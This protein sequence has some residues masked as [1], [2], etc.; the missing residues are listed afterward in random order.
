M[1]RLQQSRTK[2]FIAPLIAIIILVAL[3]IGGY[4]FLQYQRAKNEKGVGV[5][6]PIIPEAPWSPPASTTA[7]NPAPAPAP[8]PSTPPTIPT[9]WKTYRNEKYGFEVK[10]PSEWHQENI[11]DGSGIYLTKEKTNTIEGGRSLIIQALVSPKNMA[12]AANCK[13]ILFLG[14]LNAHDCNPGIIVSDDH[15]IIFA[16]NGTF[17]DIYDSIMDKTSKEIISAFKFIQ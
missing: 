2:G 17:F 5:P 11:R 8:S 13:T 12:E 3:G 14:D 4:V 6:V 9:D 1:M 7:Q 10:Y 16:R 15:E